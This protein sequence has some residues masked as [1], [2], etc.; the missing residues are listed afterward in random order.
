VF[1]LVLAATGNFS[2]PFSALA[3]VRL[4]CMLDALLGEALA[5]VVERTRVLALVVRPASSSQ[6]SK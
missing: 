6:I 3:V 1:G 5:Q 2:I 4:P